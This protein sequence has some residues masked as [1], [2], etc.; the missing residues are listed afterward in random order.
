[1]FSKTSADCRQKLGGLWV[2]GSRWR[3]K[4][5]SVSLRYATLCLWSALSRS[6]SGCSADEKKV[7]AYA[8]NGIPAIQNFS[9]ILRHHIAC[10]TELI[11][12]SA[13][14]CMTDFLRVSDYETAVTT[15]CRSL[16]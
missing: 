7:P 3:V 13:P 4:R 9:D 11:T 12:V 16:P 6:R 15:F 14:A 8:G 1:M 2:A 5:L 10:F